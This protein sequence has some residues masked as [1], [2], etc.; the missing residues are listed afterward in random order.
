MSLQPI[1][2]VTER[3]DLSDVSDL[4]ESALAEID[5][6]DGTPVP[7]GRAVAEMTRRLLRLADGLNLA[8]CRVREEYWTDR[9]Q[10]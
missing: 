9:G 7:T 10:A 8:S 6:L 2:H 4:L 5:D 3:V 1:K